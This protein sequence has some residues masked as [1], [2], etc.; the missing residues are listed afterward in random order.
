MQTGHGANR[1]VM[2]AYYGVMVVVAL[3]IG[4]VVWLVR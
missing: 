3:A 4:L 2:P 1:W